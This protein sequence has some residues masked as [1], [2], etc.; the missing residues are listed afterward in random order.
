MEIKI[1]DE[2]KATMSF[3]L[4]KATNAYA[5]ALRRTAINSI[6]TF[7]ID[8]ATF[9][10]NTS[11]MF[12]EYISHRIG[13][14]PIT[15]PSKGYSETDS[16]LFTLEAEGPKTVYSGEL[17]SAEKDVKVANDNIPIIKL[18]EGQK[19]RLECKAMMGIAATH[20]KFQPGLIT[21]DQK[22]EGTFEF[23]VESFGQMPSKEIIN[24]AC[25]IIKEHAKEL[26]K[27]VKKI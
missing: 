11:A 26:T 25:D 13:L 6:N 24:K 16:I 3:T 15:T 8:K 9:Y 20:A 19:I 2:S 21:Y 17:K 27:E 23:Y 5:N 14:I 12:D 18:A 7:A 22:G 10:E 4:S 1:T